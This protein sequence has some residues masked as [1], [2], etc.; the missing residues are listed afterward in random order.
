MGQGVNGDNGAEDHANHQHHHGGFDSRTLSAKVVNLKREAY[1][2][3]I[4]RGSKWGNPF[5]IG[6]DGDRMEVIAK[7]REHL[8]RNQHLIR[9]A[10][11]EL[12]GKRL[13]CYCAPHPCHGDILAAIANGEVW[14]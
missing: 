14:R 9:A 12:V 13:G 11:A 8:R 6:P 4:G 7:Y 2:V 10:K 5:K 1:D 3:Y